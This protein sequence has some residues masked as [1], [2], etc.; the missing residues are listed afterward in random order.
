MQKRSDSSAVLNKR[1]FWMML[2]RIIITYRVF[3]GILCFLN[4]DID[5]SW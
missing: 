5:P 1:Y 2:T 3:Y 4:T